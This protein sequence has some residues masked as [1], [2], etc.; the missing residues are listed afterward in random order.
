MA[1]APDVHR[2]KTWLAVL[3]SD[4]VLAGSVMWSIVG[5][6]VHYGFTL[7]LLFI[8]MLILESMGYGFASR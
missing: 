2:S 4:D 8:T 7:N 3:P 6:V 5:T 1:R